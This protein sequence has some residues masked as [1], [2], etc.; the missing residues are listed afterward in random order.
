[1]KKFILLITISTILLSCGGNSNETQTIKVKNLY[2]IEIPGYF[3]K[4]SNLNKDASLEYQ[5]I[6][7]DIYIM[8][9]DEPKSEFNDVIEENGMTYLYEPNLSGYAKIVK[10]TF[11]NS[12]TMDSIPNLKDRTINGLKA[13]TFHCTGTVEGEDIYWVSACL[14]GKDHYY[15]I[16]SWT[17][18]GSKEDYKPDMYAMINSFKELNKSKK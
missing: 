15:Q 9:I 4:A 1:M 17:Q 2:S 8:V 10:E 12:G 5:N 6:F 7:K 3:E 18:A 14:E 11:G 13:K 16:V